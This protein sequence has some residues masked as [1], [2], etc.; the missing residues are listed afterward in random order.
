MS[1]AGRV[2]MT[3]ALLA[4]L[5]V[6]AAISAGGGPPSQPAESRSPAS[7][8]T[9]TAEAASVLRSVKRKQHDQRRVQADRED[10]GTEVGPPRLWEGRNL[11]GDAK[12]VARRFFRAFSRYEL[13]RLD[14]AAAREIRRTAT[15]LLARALR[16]R[17]RVLGAPSR[18]RLDQI[19]VGGVE[20]ANGKAVRLELV[21]RVRRGRSSRTISIEMVP[22]VGGGW[23]VAGLGE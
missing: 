23:R 13:G 16:S 6:V 17:P 14:R 8:A 10:A 19:R 15:P 18:A 20:G 3:A 11:T 2:A 22:K 7:I 12:P 9:A 1:L 4:P 21:G 5:I